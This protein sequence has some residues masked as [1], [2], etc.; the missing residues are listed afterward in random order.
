M[1]ILAVLFLVAAAFVCATGDRAQ[2]SNP[3]STMLTCFVGQTAG[4][5]DSL[6][7]AVSSLEVRVRRLERVILAGQ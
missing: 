1:L 4:R 6:E 3:N 5:C 7:T 2:S